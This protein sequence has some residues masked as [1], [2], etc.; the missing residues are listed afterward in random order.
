FISGIVMMYVPYSRVQEAERV[1]IQSP[2][3]W[4]SCCNYESLV[5]DAQITRA[6]MESHLGMPALRLRVLG[7]RDFLFDLTNG[8]RIPIDA[9]TARKVVLEASRKNA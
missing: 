7:E 4:Q 1:R 5:D 9:D 8:A 3:L 2:I 6:Q